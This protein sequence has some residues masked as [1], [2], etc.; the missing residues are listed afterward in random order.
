M[1]KVVAIIGRPNVGKSKL[2]NYIIGKRLSIVDDKPG[3]T[4]DR[5]YA[6]AEWRG[7]KFNLVDTAGFENKVEGEIEL[8]MQEQTKFAIDIADIIVFVCNIKD[9]VTEIDKEIAQILRTSNKPVI[10]AV[11]KADKLGVEH[12]EIYEFYNLGLGEPLRL[13]VVNGIGIGD[14]LDQIYYNLPEEETEE[15]TERIKVTLIGK[16]NVGKSSL[17]NKLL[18]ENRN[19]VSNIPGTTRDAVDTPFENKMGKYVFI[20]TAGLRK[21]S[22]IDNDIELYSKDRTVMAIERADVCVLVVDAQ[23]GVT[24]QDAKVLGI[25]H[26]EGKGI[27][28]A[29]NKWDLVEKNNKTYN[30]FFKEIRNALAFCTYAPIIFLSAKTGQRTEEL[31]KLINKV[32]ENNSFTISTSIVNKMIAEAVSF[33]QPPSDK[34][35]KLKIYYGNQAGTNPPTFILFVNDKNLFHFSYQ[36]YILNTFRKYFGLEGTT[37]RLIIRERKEE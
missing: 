33:V 5:I 10:L 23:T 17:I 25:A 2:F 26:E 11:N 19:I 31:F 30:L 16:P 29:V 4:R 37:I 32:Y 24:S 22:K 18:N 21:Q 15:E 3:V 35:K 9:G 7:T 36:R 6:E 34:G 27:I 20:D 12:L 14:L 28:I 13:S 8:A 1:K